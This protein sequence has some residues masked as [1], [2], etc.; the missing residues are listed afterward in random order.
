MI[1]FLKKFGTLLKIL[2]SNPLVTF[3][4]LTYSRIK[5]FSRFVFKNTNRDQLLERYQNIYSS[6]GSGKYPVFVKNSSD[7]NILLFPAIDWNF[8]MQRPQHLSIR[9]AQKGY[10]VFY[11]STHP[12]IA[13]RRE[14]I[15]FTPLG[16]PN[17]FN[18]Q[19]SNGFSRLHNLYA[20]TACEEELEGW[21]QSLD[22]LAKF[23]APGKLVSV[24]QHPFW[25]PLVEKGNWDRKI[26]DCLD[27][28][29]SLTEKNSATLGDFERK[30]LD[31]ADVTTVTSKYLFELHSGKSHC[32]LVGNGCD[33][34]HFTDGAIQKTRNFQK[35]PI[36]GYVGAVSDWFDIDLLYNA[37]R[38]NKNYIFEIYGSTSERSKS[39]GK[40]PKNVIF[41]GEVPYA[42]LPKIVARFSVAIIPFKNDDLSKSIDPVKVYEYLASGKPIVSSYLPELKKF[43]HLDVCITETKDEFAYSIK[44]ML[45]T[46]DNPERIASRRKFAKVHDWDIVTDRFEALALKNVEE[47]K[48]V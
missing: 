21:S 20:D 36:I 34:N 12:L 14:N 44:K 19:L 31:W 24:V 48:S 29:D 43:N 25:F 33:F 13:N 42:E 30:L 5:N 27:L 4:L 15:S 40:I 38:E 22:D 9:L 6:G 16:H 10:R 35:Q 17:L 2:L 41:Q 1:S 7:R 45:S 11:L 47:Q 46:S 23:L 37:A 18:V 39:L 8:R 3:R 26:F 28:Y 32:E